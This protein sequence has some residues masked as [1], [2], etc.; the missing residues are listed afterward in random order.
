MVT[1]LKPLCECSR[2]SFT[3]KVNLVYFKQILIIW[4]NFLLLKMFP[5]HVE[6]RSFS[7]AEICDSNPCE[8]GGVCDDKIDSY[9]CH[10]APGFTGSKCEREVDE[11]SSSPFENG[12]TCMDRVNGFICVCPAGFCGNRCETE[13]D[14]CDSSPCQNNGTCTDGRNSYTCICGPG[15]HGRQCQLG[16]S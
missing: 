5:Y 6:K 15:Y 10:C 8:N 9:T 4:T 7:I 3:V 11:C 1:N 13:V 16:N 2:I 12:G 14:E